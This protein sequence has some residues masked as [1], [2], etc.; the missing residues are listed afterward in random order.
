MSSSPMFVEIELPDDVLWQVYT[1]C[2]I[3]DNLYAES[4][5]G[6]YTKEYRD[7]TTIDLVRT[8]AQ[9][10]IAEYALDP[11][12]QSLLLKGATVISSFGKD[13]RL[14]QYQSDRCVCTLTLKAGLG[15]PGRFVYLLC[16]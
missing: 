9:D 12:L 8:M 15:G 7:D 6:K 13:T 11:E 1:F 4:G 3:E 5:I 10:A 14:T 2:H 16:K